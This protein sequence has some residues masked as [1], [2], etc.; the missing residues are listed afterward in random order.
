[1]SPS[2][3]PYAGFSLRITLVDRA[4][5]SFV[6][7]RVFDGICQRQIGH[8]PSPHFELAALDD[9][10]GRVGFHFQYDA[11]RPGRHFEFLSGPKSRRPP[12][13]F[14]KNDPIG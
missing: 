7:A 12:Q 5:S 11:P 13:I 14:R 10:A 4:A 1:M 3:F 9:F 2:R 8:G 6:S